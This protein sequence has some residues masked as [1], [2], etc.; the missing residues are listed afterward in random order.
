MVI[1]NSDLRRVLREAAGDPAGE[2]ASKCDLI[3]FDEV[4]D[5]F[6]DAWQ[7]GRSPRI[8]DFLKPYPE[9]ERPGLLRE[10]LILEL[11]LRRREGE[12][13]APEEYSR[14]FPEYESVVA[15]IVHH[16][17]LGHPP[18]VGPSEPIFSSLDDHL[19]AIGSGDAVSRLADPVPSQLGPYR[20]LQQIGEGGTGVVF[21]AEQEWPIRRRVALKIIKP[22][23]DSR[24]VIARFE[25]E[26]QALALMDHPNIAKIL[27]AGITDTGRPYFVMELVKGIQITD[28]CDEARLSPRERLEL[29]VPVCLAIQH[30]H[31]KAVIHR[32]IKPSNVLVSL[33][34]G[35]P[36]PKVIDFG[37][38]KAIEQRL[39]ERTLLTQHGAIVGTLQYMS[40]EQA[41]NSA[42]D[43]DTRTDV[44]A[45]GVLLFELLTGT[46]PLER[47]RLRQ[48]SYLDILRRI[49]EEEPP[50]LSTRLSKT[51][52]I[53]AIAA[54]RNTEPQ[55]LARMVRGELDWIAMKALE[56]DRTRRYATA[57][58]LALDLQRYLAGEPLEAGPPSARY[59]MR[60]FARKHR[61]SLAGAAAFVAL[62]VIAMAVSV[63]LAVQAT[64]SAAESRAVL[65]FLDKVMAIPRP[66]GPDGGLGN[67]RHLPGNGRRPRTEDRGVL[68]GPASRRGDRPKCVGEHLQ[69]SG[70][71]EV[72]H[73]TTRA[74][75]GAAA[76]C[77][78]T[79]PP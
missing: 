37:V 71:S 51:E 30:A 8:E 19:V 27:D 44:Y 56:K 40:P 29:L 34:D 5:L 15:S 32:D 79:Q 64:R 72:C 23:M 69:E 67:E 22:G 7:D 73:T 33:Y 4:C 38:A 46:T 48:D 42:Q 3:R 59:R 54:Q 21:M 43:I 9:L 10:L 53:A 18:S 63:S 17:N 45:L 31:Q 11:E 77:F 68:Q 70:R 41:E 47:Q 13:P 57:R 20:I 39:T 14:R 35:H 12:Q 1:S 74:G 66:P 25:A 76:G 58:D 62:S 65:A 24:G 2:S 75:P 50:K 61:A 28:Y 26:R 36:V 55:K 52:Q 78:G 49:R 6:V 60:K 16:G